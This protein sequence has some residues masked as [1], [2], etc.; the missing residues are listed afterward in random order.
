MSGRVTV[1]AEAGVN[2]NGDPALALALVDAAADAGAD[3]VKFQTFRAEALAVAAAPKAAYQ[4]EATGAGE[5]QLDMLRRL[6]L[7]PEAHRAAQA[8]CR[9]RGIRFLSTPYDLESLRFLVEEMNV[10]TI[11]IGSGDL[12]NAPLLVATARSRRPAILSTGMGSLGEV[13]AAL[14]ALAFG[15][16]APV[17]ARPSR[18]AFARAYSADAGRAALKAKVT[19]LHC[20]T[21]YPAPVEEANLRAMETMRRAFALPVGFSDHTPGL[22]AA[23]AAAALGAAVIEKHLTLDRTMPGPDHAASLEPKDFALLVTAVRATES[24]LGD[25]EKKPAPSEIKN[26]AAARKSLFARRAVAKGEI[27]TQD[28]LAVLR[29][30]IGVS[31]MEYFDRLGHHATRDYAAGEA[32]DP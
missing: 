23:I 31:A 3:I 32:L 14:G 2:H 9:I 17:D 10:E 12:T 18:A 16:T 24:A 11:K 21:E 30:G 6:E 19:L 25:G 22:T 26:T 5:S 7:S 8:R 13:E 28:N 20:T 1:I 29:P 27:L 15:Y 4:A